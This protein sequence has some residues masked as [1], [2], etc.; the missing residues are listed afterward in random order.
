MIMTLK[1]NI[2]E[3]RRQVATFRSTR[4]QILCEMHSVR[5]VSRALARCTA[6]LAW[7]RS[8]SF[9][10]YD[11]VAASSAAFEALD[12]DN[13]GR[14]DLKGLMVSFFALAA[15]WGRQGTP[16]WRGVATPGQ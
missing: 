10:A 15:P 8:I 14:I 9:E 7:R 4:W 12:H 1:L 11:R 2:I 6:Q 13:D 3:P 5:V 16:C